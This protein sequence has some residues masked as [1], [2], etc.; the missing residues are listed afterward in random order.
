MARPA[1]QGLTP[2]QREVLDWVKTYIRDHGMAPTMREIGSAFGIKSSSVF[3]L[4]EAMGRK[5]F[6]ERHERKARS[7]IVKGRRSRHECGCQEARVVGRIAA[8]R[9]IEAIQHDRGTVPVAK[10]LLRGREA[11]A[12]KVEGDSMI[13]AGILDG[14]YVIVRKQE[15]AEE[16]DVVVALIGDEATL[17]R[18]HRE[19]GRIR[20]DPAN[21][22]MKPI[23]V[24]SGEFRLQGIVVAVHRML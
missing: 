21:R 1:T 2:R 11:F 8:G 7:L 6:L 22:R 9:P 16:G 5:G 3:D 23:Y 15:T 20:L 19:E 12:L 4:I 17:K 10:D 24:D 13:E 18:F 14:D